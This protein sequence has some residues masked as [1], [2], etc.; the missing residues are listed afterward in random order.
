MWD[1]QKAFSLRTI[2]VC[3]FEIIDGVKYVYC[4]FIGQ[5]CCVHTVIYVPPVRA[6]MRAT[7]LKPDVQFTESKIV[8]YE[9]LIML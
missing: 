5:K 9:I 2:K 8:F 6:Y 7:C 1:L 4:M 3:W